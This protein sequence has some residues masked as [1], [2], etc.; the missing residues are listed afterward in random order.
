MNSQPVISS[1]V[2]RGDKCFFVSTI[3]RDC[4]AAESVSRYNETMVWPYDY[5]K[6]KRTD[7]FIYQTDDM[8]C[9]IEA[10]LRVCRQLSVWGCIQ[11]K[12]EA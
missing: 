10:H 9:S 2:H 5:E 11:E 7:N 12:E 8:L 6:R 1:Y 4:S 3:E